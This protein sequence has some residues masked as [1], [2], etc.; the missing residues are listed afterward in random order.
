MLIDLVKT[1]DSVILRKKTHQEEL[2]DMDNL[3]M[4]D[5]KLSQKIG[6]GTFG[7]VYTGVCRGRAVAIKV[8]KIVKEVADQQRNYE[9]EVDTLKACDC[10]QIV[11]FYGVAESPTKGYHLIMELC[12]RGSLYHVMNSVMYNFG[13]DRFFYVST[14][15]AKGLQY[16]HSIDLVH[17]D[18]KSLNILVTEDWGIKLCDFGLTRNVACTT[19]G[20][21]RKLR[22][23]P[24]WSA[25]EIMEEKDF[26]P[27]SDIYGLS[28]VLWELVFRCVN[29]KYQRPFGEFRDISYDYQII[30]R[31]GKA[32]ALR[33]TIPDR[34]HEGVAK[35]IRESWEG[36]P[37]LRP[38]CADILARLDHLQDLYL[39]DK[40]AFEPDLKN[41]R[42]PSASSA[43]LAPTTSREK[44]A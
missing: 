39:A 19:D 43:S 31:A 35:L 1:G 34:C 28:V 27:K 5:V 13:F 9:H 37:D 14:E 32:N 12:N 15:I 11:K 33:P 6:Q 29:G 8:M 30:V 17:R 21:L 41:T 22:T 10:P 26:T 2:G 7:K 40:T 18:F 38:S 25:P 42:S 24:A 23:T 44:L 16:L 36:D 4:D 20:T 3:T